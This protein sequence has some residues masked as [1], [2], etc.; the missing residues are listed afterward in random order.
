MGKGAGGKKSGQD[1]SAG[2]WAH[3]VLLECWV[4]PST[5]IRF[6]AWKQGQQAL[7]AAQRHCLMSSTQQRVAASP[8]EECE[9]D[10]P[11][12]A[13]CA[14]VRQEENSS[15][16]LQV[17]RGIQQCEHNPQHPTPLIGCR[18]CNLQHDTPAPRSV[19]PSPPSF[20]PWAVGL[21][22]TPFLQ[23][24][25]PPRLCPIFDLLNL[26]EGGT[27]PPSTSAQSWPSE[28]CFHGGLQPTHGLVMAGTH[29]LA[30]PISSQVAILCTNSA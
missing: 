11:F 28:C 8:Q 9:G 30:F 24:L 15:L 14:P 18:V 20:I 4:W 13:C 7:V 26:N 3:W 10:L 21:G 2:C 23:C 5:G 19:H 1:N 29:L 16:A 27:R 6:W 25:E 17:K 12:S 22:K